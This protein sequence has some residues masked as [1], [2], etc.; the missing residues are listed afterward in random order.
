M[1]VYSSYLLCVLCM[2]SVF[3]TGCLPAMNEEPDPVDSKDRISDASDMTSEQKD[4]SEGVEDLTEVDD[5]PC[6]QLPLSMRSPTDI[7]QTVALINALPK[8]V[9]IPCFISALPRPLSIHATYGQISAQPAMGRRSPRI[10]ILRG[11]L[12]LSIA[13]E[14][15]GSHL[16]EFGLLDGRG[17]SFK[18]E[19]EFPIEQDLMPSAPYLRVMYDDGMTVCAFC[20]SQEVPKHTVDGATVYRSVALRPVERERVFIN[21]LSKEQAECNVQEEYLRCK[22]LDALF[23]GELEEGYFPEDLATFY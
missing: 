4:Q 10:F 18:G 16:L 11:D 6:R 9:T 1:R 12:I 21:D 22:I 7:E 17:D 15:D 13:L 3:Y 2:A 23:D 14:G 5:H 19:L 20:H 8:P